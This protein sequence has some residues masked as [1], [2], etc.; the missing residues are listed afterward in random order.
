ML[1]ITLC[2]HQDEG[3]FQIIEHHLLQQE[4]RRDQQMMI[5]RE[6]QVDPVTEHLEEDRHLQERQAAVA[7]EDQLHLQEEGQLPLQDGDHELPQDVAHELRLAED[8]EPL[9]EEGHGQEERIDLHPVGLQL[10]GL[11]RESVQGEDKR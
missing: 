5:R 6:F 8:L 11:D 1:L 10:V 3:W 9:Q 4:D 7:E 2:T